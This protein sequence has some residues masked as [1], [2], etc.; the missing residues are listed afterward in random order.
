M[1]QEV[2]QYLLHVKEDLLCQY[3]QMLHVAIIFSR[4]LLS[5][6]CSNLS[7][8]SLMFTGRVPHTKTFPLFPKIRAICIG[9]TPGEE[10]GNVHPT[11]K[12]CT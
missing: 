10:Q 9:R 11:C 6:V 1:K 4:I 2:E 12:L 5:I 8:I 3:K 7:S